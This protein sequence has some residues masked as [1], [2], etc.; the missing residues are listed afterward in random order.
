MNLDDNIL[1]EGITQVILAVDVGSSSIRCTAYRV[2]A[3][4]GSS[5][6]KPGGSSQQADK[7]EP[8]SEDSYAVRKIRTVEPNTGKIMLTTEDGTNLLDEIDG[9]ID[10]CLEKLRNS[11]EEFHV[12]GLGFATFCMNLIA[13]DE[14]GNPVGKEATLSYACATPSVA[15]EC[16]WLKRY[17]VLYII[18]VSKLIG[19]T[20]DSKCY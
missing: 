8:V 18:D 6:T 1:E 20:L 14:Y 17:D 5:P 7:V 19:Q 12:L 15:E 3:A 9:I 2:R 4:T 16:R 13:L 10:E 11:L